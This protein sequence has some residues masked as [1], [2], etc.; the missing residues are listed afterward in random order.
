MKKILYAFA[1][2]ALAQTC[3]AGNY[4]IDVQ[5]SGS[6]DTVRVYTK[7][8]QS[9]NSTELLTQYETYRSTVTA[10]M[11]ASQ[12]LVSSANATVAEI[13]NV[14]K[15][16]VNPDFAKELSDLKKKYSDIVKENSVVIK[17]STEDLFD[18]DTVIASLQALISVVP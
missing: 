15:T 18:I 2:C 7:D 6:T 17:K 3:H 9:L 5:S 1:L 14:L 8:Y 13:K 16:V 11:A 4:A 12:V 10:Q